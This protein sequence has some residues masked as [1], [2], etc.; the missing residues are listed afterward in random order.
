M[1]NSN[2]KFYENLHQKYFNKA[3]EEKKKK[4]RAQKD[5]ESDEKKSQGMLEENL[6][7]SQVNT[8]SEQI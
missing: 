5:E 2:L 8:Q 3:K 4:R 6:D 7:D 1:S